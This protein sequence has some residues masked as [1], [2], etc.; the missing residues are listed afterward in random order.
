MRRRKFIALTGAAAAW[1]FAA[2]AQQWTPIRRVVVL[3]GAV[4]TPSSR[5]WLS[6]LLH[7]LDELGW[8]DGSNLFTKVQWWNDRPEQ[9]REWTAEL[10]AS[11]PDVLVTFTNLAL[12]VAKPLAG[13]LPIV[14]I[15]VGDP[16]GSGYVADFARPGGN[17]TGFSSYD[18]SMG[19]KWLEVLKEAAPTTS[20]VLVVMEP[21]TSIHQAMWRS[22]EEASPRLA[23]EASQGDVH[24]GAEIEKVIKSFAQKPN[25]GLVLLPHALTVVNQSSIIAL[26]REYRLPEI[27]AL[28]E[29]ASAG[30]LVSYGLDWND[31]FGHAAEYVNEILNGTQPA[32]LPVQAPTKYQLVINLKTA[33]ALGLTVPQSLLATADEVIE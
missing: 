25:G 13:N 15:G 26:A 10:I 11:S 12:G 18:A 28:A 1:P 21:G 8:H 33:K 3:M 6:I 16:V 14:F 24:N 30:A 22:V 17:I 31:Q 20:R 19:S 7:R 27:F 29:A 5:T 23:V 9:M 4:E 32:E 2:R